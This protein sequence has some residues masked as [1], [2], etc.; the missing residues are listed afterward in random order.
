MGGLPVMGGA[1]KSFSERALWIY[2][3]FRFPICNTSRDQ[4]LM[5]RRSQAARAAS[6]LNGLIIQR[7]TNATQ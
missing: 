4:P 1:R 2:V 6:F 7:H 5:K 3:S